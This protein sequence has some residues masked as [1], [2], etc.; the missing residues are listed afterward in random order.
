MLATQNSIKASGRTTYLVGEENEELKD[1]PPPSGENNSS[2]KTT[3]RTP[4]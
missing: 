3:T 4:G 1:R 2:R